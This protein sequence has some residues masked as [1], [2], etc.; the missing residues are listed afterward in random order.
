MAI[1]PKLFQVTE[2]VRPL[3]NPRNEAS[4]APGLEPDLRR[5]GNYSPTTPANRDAKN[6]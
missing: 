4:S 5:R 6:P 2:D 1:S 3:P